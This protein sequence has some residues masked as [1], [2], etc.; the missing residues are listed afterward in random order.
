MTPRALFVGLI[1]CAMAFGRAHAD[2]P[3]WSKTQ[4]GNK[5]MVV[6]FKDGSGKDQKYWYLFTP[7]QS[8]SY[9]PV[10]FPLYSFDTDTYDAAS[11]TY[12]ISSHRAPFELVV[13]Q[14]D[15]FQ[16]PTDYF[17]RRLGTQ[18]HFNAQIQSGQTLLSSIRQQHNLPTKGPNHTPAPEVNIIIASPDAAPAQTPSGLLEVVAGSKDDFDKTALSKACPKGLVVIKAADVGNVSLTTYAPPM[19]CGNRDANNAPLLAPI[20]N[21]KLTATPQAGHVI[22][23]FDGGPYNASDP[24]SQ[25][26]LVPVA[27]SALPPGE[28]GGDNPTPGPKPG[29]K[30]PRP[31]PSPQPGHLSAIALTTH[32]KNWLDFGEYKSYRDQHAKIENA[33]PAPKD[34]HSQLVKLYSKFRDAIQ[35]NVPPAS[36]GD[37]TAER[38]KTPASTPAGIAAYIKELDGKAA[39]YQYTAADIAL[40]DDEQK[41]AQKAPSSSADASKTLL[42]DYTAERAQDAQ[43]VTSAETADHGTPHDDAK[44]AAKRT[45]ILYFRTTTKFRALLGGGQPGPTDNAG[46]TLPAELGQYFRDDR[47]KAAWQDYLKKSQAALADMKDPAK[48]AQATAALAAANKEALNYLRDEQGTLTAEDAAK[49]KHI[50]SGQNEPFWDPDTTGSLCYDFKHG[51]SQEQMSAAASKCSDADI[52]QKIKESC[53]ITPTNTTSANGVPTQTGGYDSNCVAHINHACTSVAA[54]TAPTAGGSQSHQKPDP[55]KPLGLACLNTQPGGDPSNNPGNGYTPTVIPDAP[56][57]ADGT[58]VKAGENSDKTTQ[59]KPDPNNMSHV[60]SGLG[61]ALVGLIFGTFFGPVG[62]LVGAAVGFGAGYAADKYL[63][64]GSS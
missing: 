35:K 8:G 55:S 9:N 19:F 29:P 62:V 63:I 47:S 24:D 42:D 60:R 50:L 5:W 53:K 33:K 26:K 20:A 39:G 61:G 17:A 41:K 3:D 38:A 27:V 12:K 34:K 59:Q 2:G 10:A 37:Y 40:S 31:G 58:P 1:A 15:S 57:T 45:D 18:E 30:P 28:G 25:L 49:I 7:L 14:H 51:S 22:V 6:T 13:Q 48:K 56:T 36:N 54:G 21:H 44:I 46:L 4:D 43:S 32:E 64:T 11:N 23:R 52:A 16:H